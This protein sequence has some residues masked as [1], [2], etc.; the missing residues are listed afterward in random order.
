MKA[1]WLLLVLPLA[2]ASV[3]AAQ[4]WLDARFGEFQAIE[5]ALYLPR[6]EIIRR[7]AFG[8]ESLVADIYWLRTVQYYGGKRRDVPKENYALLEPM[9]RITTGLDPEMILAYRYGAIFLSEPQPIGA[10]EPEKGLRLLEEGIQKN[11]DSWHLLFDKGFIYFW[12]LKDYRQAAEWFLRGSRHPKAPDW[13]GGL[14]AFALE[15]GGDID[16]AKYLWKK[17]YDESGNERMRANAVAHLHSIQVD[18][19]LWTLEFLI[20]RFRGGQGRNPTSWQELM[21][22]GLLKTM[23]LDPSGIPYELDSNGASARL[24]KQS[25]LKRFALPAD[26]K[27][28]YLEKLAAQ[29][30]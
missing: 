14:A 2:G 11:P 7:L 29:W 9:L 30:K 13:M 28:R 19:D 5:E 6:Q 3:F 10:A 20:G 16:T 8:Y 12:H 24:S 15:K 27:N 23:P 17:Q 25:T 18:E 1:L 4:R 22:S 21:R 26:L